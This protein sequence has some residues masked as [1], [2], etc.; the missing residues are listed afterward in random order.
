MYLFFLTRD[1]NHWEKRMKAFEQQIEKAAE[2]F[3]LL[4]KYKFLLDLLKNYIRSLLFL[5]HFIENLLFL[6]PLRTYIP[7]ASLISFS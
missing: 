4:I 1:F 2:I 7:N 3:K 6:S 5:S